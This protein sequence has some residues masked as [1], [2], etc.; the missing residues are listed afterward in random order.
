MALGTP[1]AATTKKFVLGGLSQVTQSGWISNGIWME[2]S[3]IKSQR[4]APAFGYAQ[5]SCDMP[6]SGTGSVST[7]P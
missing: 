5:S 2:I 3:V 7:S 4:P 6:S 1:A